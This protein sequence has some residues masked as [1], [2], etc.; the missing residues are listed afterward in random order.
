[1]PNPKGN[2]NWKLKYGEPTKVVRLPETLAEQ[3]TLLLKKK[4]PASKVLQQLKSLPLLHSS[5]L[6]EVAAIHLVYKGD[7]LLYIGKTANLKQWWTQ[8]HRQNQFADL[9]DVRI[10][11]FPCTQ[12]APVIEPTLIDFIE[13]ELNGQEGSQINTENKRLISYISAENHQKLKEFMAGRSL[14]EST[15][16]ELIL[17]EFFGSASGIPGGKVNDPLKRIAT[18]EQQMSEVLGKSS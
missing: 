15:A 14:T 16:V 10:A 5:Q 6:P 8:Q 4:V 9:T 7:R 12:E 3:I 13:P 1:M 18:L 11:W 2:L 17:N